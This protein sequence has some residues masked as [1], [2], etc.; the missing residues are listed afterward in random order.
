MRVYCDLVINMIPK[1][2]SRRLALSFP[3]ISLV[4]AGLLRTPPNSS[5]TCMHAVV[6]LDDYDSPSP[7]SLRRVLSESVNCAPGVPIAWRVLISSP[8]R[9]DEQRLRRVY[10]SDYSDPIHHP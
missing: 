4:R 9:P 8:H 7:R 3:I 2:P 1:R 10:A 5:T 6:D